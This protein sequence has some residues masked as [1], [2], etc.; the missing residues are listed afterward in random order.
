MLRRG[1]QRGAPLPPMPLPILPYY[2]AFTFFHAAAII[3]HA[4]TQRNAMMPRLLPPRRRCLRAADFFERRA[5]AAAVIAAA[6]LILRF[7]YAPACFSML[8]F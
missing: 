5:D 3:A 1:A 7:A 8:L 2:V 4:R 6:T